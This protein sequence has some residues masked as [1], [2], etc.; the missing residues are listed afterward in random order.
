MGAMKSRENSVPLELI[1]SC[2]FEMMKYLKQVC[3]EHH[4]QYYLAYGTLIGAVRHQGFIPWDDDVDI[5]MPRE[6]FLQLVEIMKQKPHPY[7]RMIARETTPEYSYLWPKLIDTRTKLTQ[8]G[9]WKEPVQL[10]IFI[11]IFLLD[12][13]GNSREE[14]EVRYRQAF[15]L[16]RHV[17]RAAMKMFSPWES[18]CRTIPKWIYHIPE[19]V[20]GIGYWM[21]K[22]ASFCSK[23]AYHEYEYVG[24][25]GASTPEPSRNV[26]KKEWFGSG[27]DLTFNGEL[28]QAPCNWDAVLRPEYGDYMLLPPPEKRIPHHDY[29]LELP[30]SGISE[31][32]D[33]I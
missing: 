22:H 32:A 20:M 4:L 5:H 17:K 15:L 25:M 1:Q 28:F 27:T 10:G 23:K 29:Y 11:D 21:D 33:T 31:W 16:Y 18:W 7:Y 26:W 2:E 6:D 13:A 30:D 14:A 12:G 9:D 8:I 3:D 24:A 19:K